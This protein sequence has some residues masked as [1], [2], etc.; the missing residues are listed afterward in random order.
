MAEITTS[1]IRNVALVGHNG[2]GKTSLVGALFLLPVELPGRARLTTRPAFQTTS[3]KSN[4]VDQ[5]SNFR[6]FHVLGMTTV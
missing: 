3:Q 5:A 4:A 6:F 2:A 1:Q